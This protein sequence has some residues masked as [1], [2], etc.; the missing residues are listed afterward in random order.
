[1]P[2]VHH[3]IGQDPESDVHIPEP[4]GNRRALMVVGDQL[5]LFFRARICCTNSTSGGNYSGVSE[6]GAGE[7]W[8]L[9]HL[10][11][12]FRVDSLARAR[13]PIKF[14][15]LDRLTNHHLDAL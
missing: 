15:A 2:V 14:A 12:R 8:L 7:P 9:G 3:S 11:V 13:K 4:A 1:M 5:R 10:E 6:H